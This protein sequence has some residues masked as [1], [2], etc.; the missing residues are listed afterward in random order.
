[1][2]EEKRERL[3]ENKI[4]SARRKPARRNYNKK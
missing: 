4:K 2:I 3:E 1:M